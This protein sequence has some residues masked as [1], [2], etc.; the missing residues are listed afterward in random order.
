MAPEHA[1]ALVIMA[2]IVGGVLIPALC[3]SNPRAAWLTANLITVITVA[4]ALGLVHRLIV[5]GPF[6]YS[7]AGWPPPF[8]IELQF[9]A[10]AAAIVVF[11][12][13]FAMA[14][15]FSVRY[16]P[17]IVPQRRVPLYYALALIN[18]GGLNGFVVTG[19][20]F[21]LFVFMEVFSVS[22]YALVAMTRGPRAALAA[23]KYLMLGAVSSLLV[24]LAIGVVFAQTGSLN[25]AD[26]GA[27]LAAAES[28]MPAALALAAFVIG[29]LVKAALFPVHVWLPDA[30]ATAPGPVSALLSAVVVKAGVIGVIRTL[31]MFG[32]ADPPSLAPVYPI[33]TWLGAIG[34]L[35]GA[36]AALAQ[37]DIKRML[38]WSTVTNIGYIFMGLGIGSSSAMS[39]ATIHLINHAVIKAALFLAASAMIHQ[40]GLR[41]IDDLRGLGERMPLTAIAFGL[42]MLALAG[43]PPT[44]GFVGKWLIALGALEAGQPI[45]VAVVLL[46]GLLVLAYGIRVINA[47]FFLPPRQVCV[48]RT[49]EAPISILAPIVLLTAGTLLL[50]LAGKPLLEFLAPAIAPLL[51]VS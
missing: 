17:A 29:F 49:G 36:L 32:V 7:V 46:G 16:I 39:G 45:L 3:W 6:S 35:A 8:G 15:L 26:A 38:A 2:P 20:L 43:V 33:L 5:H 12:V 37:S 40:T 31:E 28:G 21:N 4:L 47:L 9:D 30:H 48:I 27:R 41:R 19:D 11:S 18:L 44:A 10:F 23:L 25:M 1:L 51:T 50:G 24:L 14:L 42:C 13:I 22:A 34:V